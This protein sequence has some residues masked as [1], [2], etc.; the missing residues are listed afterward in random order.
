MVNKERTI[1]RILSQYETILPIPGKESLDECFFYLNGVFFFQFR[2]KDDAAHIIKADAT[3]Q[4]LM[5]RKRATTGLT[6]FIKLLNTPFYVRSL[7]I[8][9]K[10][11]EENLECV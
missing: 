7:I 10:K 1:R 8:K 3:P 5:Y 11:C 2:T 4:V 6:S 9:K